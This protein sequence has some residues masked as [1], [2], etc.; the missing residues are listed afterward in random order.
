LKDGTATDYGY[1]WFIGELQGSPLVEHGGNMGGF[2]SHVIYLPREDILVEVFMNARGKRLPE[3]LATDFAA[4]LLGKP[5][6]LR[7]VTL[8]A[9]L[10]QSYTGVYTEVGKPDVTIGLENGRLSYQRGS[11]PKLG[12]APIAKDR[13]YF[14]GTS[15]VGE[16]QRDAQGRITGFA[17]QSLRRAE[18]TL[19]KR[20]DQ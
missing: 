5:I 6:D 9:E 10:L 2:M 11:N 1:G 14:D 12:L 18:K 19:L 16:I 20:R 3:L 7:P 17:L 13:L 15:I 4:M 8:S